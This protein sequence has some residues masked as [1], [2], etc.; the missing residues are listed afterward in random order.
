VTMRFPQFNVW[1][2]YPPVIDC[3]PLESLSFVSKWGSMNKRNTAC[4]FHLDWLVGW[5]VC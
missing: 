4:T 1:I 5:F 3:G 2:G